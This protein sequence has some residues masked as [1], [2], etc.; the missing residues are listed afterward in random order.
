[1]ADVATPSAAK[2]ATSSEKQP[3]VKPEQPDEAKYK[4]ELAK[5]EKEHTAAQEKFVSAFQT[6]LHR[7]HVFPSSRCECPLALAA[8]CHIAAHCC[9][10]LLIKSRTLSAANL[11]SH[12]RTTRILRTRSANKSSRQS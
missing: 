7:F 6:P 10:R 8:I 11:T 2:V 5:A 12:D 4:E 9:V 3:V 1:M